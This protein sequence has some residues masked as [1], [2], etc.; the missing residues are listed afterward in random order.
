MTFSPSVGL[1]TSSRGGRPPATR[2]VRPVPA[3]WFE[4]G[5]DVSR[6]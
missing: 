5:A 3:L 2:P 1:A 4:A 6:L